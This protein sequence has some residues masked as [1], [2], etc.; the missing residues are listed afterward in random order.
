MKGVA[1]L[2][3]VMFAPTNA[4]SWSEMLSLA[5]EL[6]NHADVLFLVGTEINTEKYVEEVIKNRFD[7]IDVRGKSPSIVKDEQ[8]EQQSVILTIKK[9]VLKN[10]SLRDLAI[11]IYLKLQNS[12]MSTVLIKRRVDNLQK[13]VAWC[14]KTLIEKEIDTVAVY[15]DRSGHTTMPLLKACEELG[16]RSLIVPV[17]LAVGPDSLLMMRR[18]R[19]EH[20]QCHKF[21]DIHGME[22]QCMYDNVSRQWLSFYTFFT[23]MAF[24]T[25]GMLSANPWILG[26]G[27][28]STVLADGE[29]TRRR[30]IEHGCS[31]DKIAIT[32]H[33]SHDGLLCTY[34]N[35][36]N[37]K[38][39]LCE[40]YDI[41][42]EKK[43]VIVALPHLG[44]HGLLPWK[45]HWEEIRY[46]CHVLSSL[47]ATILVSLHPKM[48]PEQYQFIEKEYG[49][50]I[51]HERLKDVL[52]IADIFLATFSST[53]QWAIL[54]KIP[55]IVFDFYDLNY[56][57]Y[58]WAKSLTVINNKS[59]FE[60]YLKKMV[61]D[62]ELLAARKKQAKD[63]ALMIS[64]FDGNCTSR[65]IKQIL[66]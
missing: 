34:N 47:D 40:K 61:G 44:E 27:L 41:V 66:G 43:V 63:D 53:V 17:V 59:K 56:N 31:P 4:T 45:E 1:A 55:T 29:D 14:K 58:N 13:L 30:Y 37:V 16:V 48:E 65:I 2:K 9:W 25:S 7:L 64:P 62:D 57:V 3:R 5:I 33:P 32:G 23:S 24:N 11:A 21:R 50:T 42:L 19:K 22:Q 46:I 6:R 35:R 20:Q 60:D 36:D 54:C 12:I 52:P 26:G 28:V 39:M 49:I 18:N 8:I 38:K 15:D 10:D 51:V